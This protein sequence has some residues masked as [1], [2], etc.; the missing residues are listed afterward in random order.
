MPNWSSTLHT[1]IWMPEQRK[2]AVLLKCSKQKKETTHE[3]FH[4]ISLKLLAKEQKVRLPHERGCVH[5]RGKWFLFELHCKRREQQARMFHVF[6]SQYLNGHLLKSQYRY[7]VVT[8]HLSVT[9][10]HHP[11]MR[12]KP[13]CKEP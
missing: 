13:N 2:V 8:S 11:P 5:L 1:C 12:L 10:S 7:G 4:Y 6:L 3:L 9:S